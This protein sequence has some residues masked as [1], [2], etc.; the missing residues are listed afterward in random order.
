MLALG[1]FG[2]RW[3]S[4][5]TESCDLQPLA[6]L[7]WTLLSAGILPEFVMTRYDSLG[8]CVRARLQNLF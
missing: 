8:T 2:L 4:G 3:V 1:N 6:G 5:W 7:S